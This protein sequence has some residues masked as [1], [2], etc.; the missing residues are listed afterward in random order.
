MCFSLR[1]MRAKIWK[2]RTVS[3]LFNTETYARDLE[4]LFHLMW[5]RHESGL[6]VDHIVDINKSTTTLAASV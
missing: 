4:Q 2:L 6:P 1:K 5:K 3:E